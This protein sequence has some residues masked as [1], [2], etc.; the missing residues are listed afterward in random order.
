MDLPLDGLDMMNA[1][2]LAFVPQKYADGITISA[3]QVVTGSSILTFLCCLSEV[4][5]I[6]MSQ[7][8]TSQSL[9]GQ[10][11]PLRQRGY[12]HVRSGLEFIKLCSRSTQLSMKLK[13]L[14]NSKIESFIHN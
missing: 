13:Y 1:C 3:D 6:D 9:R 11:V 10:S 5:Y 2:S 8:G 14:K 12:N 4:V 7:P